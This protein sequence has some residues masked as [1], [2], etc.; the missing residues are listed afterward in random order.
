MTISDIISQSVYC[1]CGTIQQESD[2]SKLQSYLLYNKSL[3][4]KFDTIIVCHNRMPN[5]S[6]ID[7]DR[8][9]KCWQQV[10][11]HKHIILTTL[12]DNKGYVLG[13]IELD[14]TLL[15]N[16]KSLSK[17]YIWKSVND[18]LIS[19]NILNFEISIIDDILFIPEIGHAGCPKNKEE[20]DSFIRR[21]LDCDLNTIGPQCNFYIIKNNIDYYYDMKI[22]KEQYRSFLND[23]DHEYH[24]KECQWKLTLPTIPLIDLIK[25]MKL[26]PKLL[27]SDNTFKNLINIVMQFNIADSSLKNILFEDIGIC[28]FH[29]ENEPVIVI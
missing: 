18:I 6:D 23:P 16:C 5:I 13:C 24:H 8:Y 1:S 20:L 15:S 10:F 14:N 26:S 29:F 11:Q 9:N 21:Y 27:L 28:H 22:L 25:R 2:I 4:D 12:N 19:D 3:I 17:E 7:F